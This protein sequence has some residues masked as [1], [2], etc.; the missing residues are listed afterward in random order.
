MKVTV[1]W[2]ARFTSEIELLP[3]DLEKIRA[4][5]ISLDDGWTIRNW[6]RQQTWLSDDARDG[7]L[8]MTD[9]ED[10]NIEV[11]TDDG[12]VVF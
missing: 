1:D 3:S 11:L 8:Q 10:T 2:T 12:T 7:I 9:F 5:G 6:L 4:E